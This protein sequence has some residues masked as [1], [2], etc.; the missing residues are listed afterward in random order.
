MHLEALQY[1]TSYISPCA[2]T[3][4]DLSIEASLLQLPTSC[5]TIKFMAM[6]Y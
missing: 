5:P 3:V 4:L 1:N 6:K 2:H